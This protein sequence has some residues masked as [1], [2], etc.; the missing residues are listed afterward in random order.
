MRIYRSLVLGA[1]S[2]LLLGCPAEPQIADMAMPDLAPLPPVQFSTMGDIPY[3]SMED[4]LFRA[5]VAG[6]P[7]QSLFVMHLGDIKTGAD[8]CVESYYQTT[9]KILSLSPIPAF[10]VPGDNEWNDCPDPAAAWVLW[11]KYFDRFDRRFAHS[12][13]VQYQPT[14]PENLAFVSGGVLFVG[15]NV[16]GGRI[17]DAEEWRT[18]HADGLAFVRQ[19]RLLAGPRI[20]SIVIQA[21]ALLF[22]GHLDFKQGLIEEA[23]AFG[24]SVLYLHGDGHNFT[25]S[26]PYGLS[27][28]LDVQIDQG[29]KAPP[30]TVTVTHDAQNPFIF[31]RGASIVQSSA[32][33]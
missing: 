15:L 32:C 21:Q 23:Q 8:P 1:L 12:L 5:Q 26:R 9:A 14:H 2:T 33:N 4:D 7:K 27:N 6:L 16:V 24:G 11:T 17:H 20:D 19:Q 10:I 28:L 13:P 29:N 31:D 25:C 30:L 3:G 22:L 18:R